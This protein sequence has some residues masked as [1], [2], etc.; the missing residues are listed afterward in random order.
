MLSE[1]AHTEEKDE[2]IDILEEV[3]SG[4]GNACFDALDRARDLIDKL[5]FRRN[6]NGEDDEE[7]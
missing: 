1:Y 7:W 2:A 5:K 4:D 3:L 6:P